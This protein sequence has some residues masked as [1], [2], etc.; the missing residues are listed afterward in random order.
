MNFATRAQ[1]Y[2]DGWVGEKSTPKWLEGFVSNQ[3]PIVVAIL[4]I[5]LISWRAAELTWGM[6]PVPDVPYHRAPTETQQ[7]RSDNASSNSDTRLSKVS[8]LHLFGKAGEVKKPKKVD[9][10]APETRLNLTLHGV[11][12]ADLPENGAAI[13]AKG[14][15]Q[16][17]HKVGS[18]VMSGVTLQAV[19]TDRVVLLRKGQSEVL[20]FPKLKNNSAPSKRKSGKSSKR[21]VKTSDNFGPGPVSRNPN[22]SKYRDMLKQEPLKVFEYVRFVPVKSRDG[23]KGYRILPQK[24]RELYNQLGVRPSDL[25]TAVNGVPL[26]NDKEAMKLMDQLKDASNLQVDIIRNGQS[27]TLSFDLN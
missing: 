19:Y 7:T 1:S 14:S 26:T 11:F 15:D 5:L 16:K 6:I 25:V 18:A 8:D 12:V 24:N 4:L 13:I 22:L 21:T 10:K 23:M 3:L 17:Y 9:K 27:R 2:L 20:R